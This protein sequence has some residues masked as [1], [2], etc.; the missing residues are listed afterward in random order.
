MREVVHHH[1]AAMDSASRAGPGAPL[2]MQPRRTSQARNALEHLVEN[3]PVELASVLGVEREAHAARA[4]RVHRFAALPRRVGAEANHREI[5]PA[6]TGYR[7]EVHRIVEAVRVRVH[8]QSAR[9]AERVVQRE[10]AQERIGACTC[11]YR[12][13]ETSPADRARKYS[14]SPGW[15]RGRDGAT[16]Q[17]VANSAARDRSPIRLC[18]YTWHRRLSATPRCSALTPRS[19]STRR[20][21][22]CGLRPA[23]AARR[24]SAGRAPRA[25]ASGAIAIGVGAD[26]MFLR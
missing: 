23:R 25:R 20:R 14:R 6:G 4:L 21:T 15:M 9:N 10:R 8:D 26:E 18:V 2:E 5:A 11:V 22:R 3:A 12:G 13:M 24:R 16:G 19:S 7:V 17:A 1:V